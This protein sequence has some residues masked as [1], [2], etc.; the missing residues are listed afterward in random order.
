MLDFL[1][2]FSDFLA[3][4]FSAVMI[5]PGFKKLY[6]MNLLVDCQA[7][8]HSGLISRIF[9]CLRRV[10]DTGSPRYVKLELFRLWNVITK[11]HSSMLTAHLKSRLRDFIQI[12]YG[13]VESFVAE[14]IIAED[15]KKKQV[16]KRKLTSFDLATSQGEDFILS[17]SNPNTNAK[18]LDVFGIGTV[19]NASDECTAPIKLIRLALQAGKFYG[20]DCIVAAS[21]GALKGIS[22]RDNTFTNLIPIKP[23]LPKQNEIT[24]MIWSGIDQSEVLTVQMDRQ[25][26]LYDT[27][28]NTISPLFK[29]DGEYVEIT[30]VG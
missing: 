29:A 30:V 21:T 7:S 6:R 20:M 5:S 10:V 25:L 24:S 26:N 14:Q 4:F 18:S 13:D 23:L 28:S 3:I 2:D 27:V 12:L 1:V 19:L 15:H 22:L 9:Q 17:V 11:C 16:R 8:T